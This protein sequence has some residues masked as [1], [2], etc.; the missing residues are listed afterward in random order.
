VRYRV[1]VFMAVVGVRVA[2]TG[3]VVASRPGP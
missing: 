2:G 1:W 3:S